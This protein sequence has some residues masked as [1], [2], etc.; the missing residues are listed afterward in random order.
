MSGCLTRR[1]TRAPS[2]MLN[3]ICR[4]RSMPR[5]SMR[6][7]TLAQTIRSTNPVTAIRI[8]SH[9]SY[10]S[11]MLVIPAPP[12]LRN[13]VCSGNSA[14][15]LT[16]IS[17]QC[18]RSHWVSSARIEPRSVAGVTPGWRRPISSSQ[19]VSYFWRSASLWTS[20]SVVSGRKKSGRVLRSVSP[21]KPGGRDPYDRKRLVVD[22]EVLPITDGSAPYRSRHKR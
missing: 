5:T 14:R 22:I 1:D 2:A 21:K 3:E 16:L 15:S 17:S 13:N 4:R 19:C 7:A 12:G 11:R 20:G 6:L 8:S 9:C 10:C 18:E